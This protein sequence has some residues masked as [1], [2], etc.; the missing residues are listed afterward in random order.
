MCR[1]RE[2]F[3]LFCAV[4]RFTEV[5]RRKTTKLQNF[6][7]WFSNFLMN[8]KYLAVYNIIGWINWKKKLIDTLMSTKML[9]F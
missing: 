4:E 2:W 8:I 5:F 3:M 9:V 1:Y 6:I 7:S